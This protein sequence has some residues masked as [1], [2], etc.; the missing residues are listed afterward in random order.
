MSNGNLPQLLQIIGATSY[1]EV[2]QQVE[3]I[4]ALD[5]K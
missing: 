4:T 3:E 2:A 5:N 1:F